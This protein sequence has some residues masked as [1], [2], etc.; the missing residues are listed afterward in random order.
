MYYNMY[1]FYNIQ[2][3]QPLIKYY[4]GIINYY[5]DNCNLIIMSILLIWINNKINI[6][7]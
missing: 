1:M 3:R 2:L 4:S 5:I 7:C 6:I